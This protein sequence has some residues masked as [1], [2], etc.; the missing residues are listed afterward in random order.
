MMQH[1]EKV[2]EML[3]KNCVTHPAEMQTFLTQLMK[4]NRATTQLSSLLLEQVIVELG[5]LMM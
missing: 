2:A 1:K 3:L 5:V 4:G